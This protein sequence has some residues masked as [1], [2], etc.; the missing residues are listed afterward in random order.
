MLLA[1]DTVSVS[2]KI[3][4][5]H[6]KDHIV[7][8]LTIMLYGFL[9]RPLGEPSTLMGYHPF[10]DVDRYSYDVISAILGSFFGFIKSIH[11]EFEIYK[12]D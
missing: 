6:K 12:T 11:T 1:R 5:G 2:A 9:K 3:L 7:I 8:R 10:R 4:N